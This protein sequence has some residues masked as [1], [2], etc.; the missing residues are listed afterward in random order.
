M[1]G[2]VKALFG[3]GVVLDVIAGRVASC[4][5]VFQSEATP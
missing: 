4:A 1:N 5:V 3:V 2:P